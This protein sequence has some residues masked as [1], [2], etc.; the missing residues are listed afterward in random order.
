MNNNIVELYKSGIS[1]LEIHDITGISRPKISKCLKDN[2]IKIR[3]KYS[4]QDILNAWNLYKKNNSLEKT[5]NELNIS[6]STLRIRFQELGLRDFERNSVNDNK[7][8]ELYNKNKTTREIA[9]IL[10]LS[11][12]SIEY[13]L[14]VNKLIKP[15]TCIYSF[16]HDIFKV[17][18]TEEKAYWLGFLYADGCIRN[19]KGL[20]LCLAAKDKNHLEKFKNFMESNKNIKFRK[21]SNS[22]RLSIDSIELVQDLIRLGCFQNK[23]LILDFPTN[24]QVPEH[25]IHHFMRGYFDGDGCIYFGKDK[26]LRFILVGTNMFLNK[27]EEYILKI[28][29]RN[30]PNKRSYTGSAEELHYGGNKQVK[31]IFNF[32]YKDATIYLERK[33]EIFK[34]PS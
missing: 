11:K 21:S 24:K 8:I 29:N 18:D 2:N 13:C 15:R 7:I 4:K 28:L 1:I 19:D 33:F 30:N 14:R 34:L 27:Y 12:G 20:D 17:I 5:A 32:L 10:N 31:K 26:S 9:K 25:L 6:R 22:Y 16:N 23:S 3:G